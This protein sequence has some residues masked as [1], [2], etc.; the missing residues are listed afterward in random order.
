MGN[1]NILKIFFKT[2]FS[3][4]SLCNLKVFECTGVQSA[5]KKVIGQWQSPNRPFKPIRRI[6]DKALMA[7]IVSLSLTLFS[8]AKQ[9]LLHCFRTLVGK[10]GK[11]QL[12]KK[13]IKFE[14]DANRNL[15]MVRID[16]ERI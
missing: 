5:M 6:H 16:S 13:D 11:F 7:F 10:A 3:K 14:L 12:E 1:N 2:W 9:S 15:K 8:F 4:Y